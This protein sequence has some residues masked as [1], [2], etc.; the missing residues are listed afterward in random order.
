M[1]VDLVS[2]FASYHALEVWL[3]ERQIAVELI[4]QRCKKEHLMMLY[5][6]PHFQGVTDFLVEVA[7][8]KGRLRKGGVPDLDGTARSILRDWV[9]GRI[10]YY[11]SPP[12]MPTTATSIG[13]GAALTSSSIGTVTSSDVDSATLLT[14]FAPAFDLGALFGEADAAAFE[15]VAAAGPVKGVKMDGVEIETE[16]A[17]VGW[18][19]GDEP[20]EMVEDDG[21]NFDDL[22]EEEEDDDEEEEAEEEDDAMEADEP[23]APVAA[24]TTK[25]SAPGIVSVAPP[26]KKG[27]SVSF[28]KKALGPTGSSS[29]V[30]NATTMNSKEFVS[31]DMQQNKSIK[32]TQ[33][34][35]KKKA[36]RVCYCLL[37]SVES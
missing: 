1:L 37:T 9:S 21:L 3:T 35:D 31:D 32:K 34:K 22:A 30:A 29:T 26:T 36:A 17:N 24:P 27:K 28:A 2:Q 19:T 23:P 15:A 13:S 6:I 18:V 7:R 14:S 10:P 5:N 20:E 4:L 8:A 33:K 12:S 11:T 16:D 25:R